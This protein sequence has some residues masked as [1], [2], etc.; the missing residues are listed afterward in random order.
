MSQEDEKTNLEDP[1]MPISIRVATSSGKE[2]FFKIKRST[3]LGKMMSAFCNHQ[4]IPERSVKFL[5]DGRRITED[6]TPESL[7]LEEN[8][9]ID[10]LLEQTG[11]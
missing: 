2:L 3:P 10:A 4:K 11:G 9:S 8:D 7:G 1:N 6:S 5:F